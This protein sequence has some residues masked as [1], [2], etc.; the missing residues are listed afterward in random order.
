MNKLSLLLL[1]VI[2]YQSIYAQEVKPAPSVRIPVRIDAKHINPDYYSLAFV[3]QLHKQIDD[4]NKWQYDVNARYVIKLFS[5]GDT[6]SAHG[7]DV[8]CEKFSV[9]LQDSATTYKT[10]DSELPEYDTINSGT[11]YMSEAYDAI[12]EVRTL[13]E[14]YWLILASDEPSNR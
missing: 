1:L 14:S 2:P 8:F 5:Q 4:S 13:L 10:A 12:F 7:E 9:Y 11:I 6:C 3:K